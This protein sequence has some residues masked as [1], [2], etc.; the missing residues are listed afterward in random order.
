MMKFDAYLRHEMAVFWITLALVGAVLVLSCVKSKPALWAGLLTLILAADLLNAGRGTSPTMPRDQ[1]YPDTQLTRFLQE[2][3]Q[4]CRIGVIEAMIPPG[5]LV[6][7]GVEEISGYDGLYPKRLVQFQYTL[8]ADV[9]KSVEPL[10][11]IEYYLYDP[12]VLKVKPLSTPTI[13]IDRTDWLERVTELDGL[14]VYK[15]KR[16]L[17]RAFLVGRARVVT[18][19][20]ERF[21]AMRDPAFDPRKEV[22]LD[23]PLETMPD[24][25]PDDVGQASMARYSSTRVV[26][27][28]HAAED[29][30]LVLC[31]QY[32][33]GWRATVDGRPTPVNPAYHAFRCVYVP[34]GDHRVE[35]FYFPASFRAGLAMSTATLLAMLVIGGVR[36]RALRSNRRRS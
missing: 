25:A 16:V 33:P 3:P 15:N 8:L 5:F 2:L 10:Y 20:A 1:L 32:Y 24:A 36:V 14:E 27:D 30:L 6:P 4:P 11:G 23:A 28:V 22:L 26:I 35:F 19:M 12:V 9:W 34:A 7:Y 31:D 29:C 21:D 18:D 13:P 17:P